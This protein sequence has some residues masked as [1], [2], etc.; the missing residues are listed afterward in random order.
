MMH[1]SSGLN[2]WLSIKNV[3]APYLE[4]ST[5]VDQSSYFEKDYERRVI[6]HIFE[7]HLIAE[8]VR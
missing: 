6:F 7:N 4:Y 5:A 8:I 2:I 1:E 3:D